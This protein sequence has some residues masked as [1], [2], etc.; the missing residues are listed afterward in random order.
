MEG[1]MQR[2]ASQGQVNG[3]AAIAG[4]G[5]A[6]VACA[7]MVATLTSSP[8]PGAAPAQSAEPAKQCENM[9]LMILVSTNT[10]GGTVRFREGNYLSPP[11]TLSTVPQTVVFPRPRSTVAE[12]EEVITIEGNATDLVTTS[13]VTQNRNVYPKISGILAI[14]A[15]WRPLQPCQTK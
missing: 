14:D 2:T 12:I 1:D 10:G 4:L 9:P 8:S 3:S 11:I 6:I 7:I 13:P 5:A 15:K